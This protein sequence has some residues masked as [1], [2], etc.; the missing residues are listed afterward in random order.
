M[1]RR[2]G[3]RSPNETLL[4]TILTFCDLIDSTTTITD[5]NS[6]WNLKEKDRVFSIINI[7]NIIIS[8]EV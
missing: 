8:S 6:N 2:P 5:G 4:E 3:C 1:P 7:L